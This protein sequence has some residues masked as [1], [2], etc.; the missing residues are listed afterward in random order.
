MNKLT[1]PNCAHGFIITDAVKKCP[2]CRSKE[3]QMIRYAD[4]AFVG[5]SRCGAVLLQN[6]CPCPQCGAA[7]G[8][9]KDGN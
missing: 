7:C 8:L 1:C 4:I 3:F 2:N 5:C 6:D 9:A